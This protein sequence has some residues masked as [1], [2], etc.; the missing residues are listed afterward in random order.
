M[1][2]K[3][4]PRDRVVFIPVKGHV[5]LSMG[6]VF[7][8]IDKTSQNG[9]KFQSSPASVLGSFSGY[10]NRVLSVMIA[11]YGCS[12]SLQKGQHITDFNFLHLDPIFYPAFI[13]H[14]I[15]SKMNEGTLFHAT[16]T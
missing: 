2:R 1:K 15:F 11:E 5:A 9:C 16:C 12:M 6:F 4:T 13:K 14:C 10:K 8:R 3:K 7:F